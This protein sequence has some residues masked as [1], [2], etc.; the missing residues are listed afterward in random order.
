MDGLFNPLDLIPRIP[1]GDWIDGFISWLL[2]YLRDFTRAFSG[3]LRTAIDYFTDGLVFIPPLLLI[4]FFALVAW[5]MT[6][7]SVAIFSFLGLVL[8][9][10]MGLWGAAM[11]TLAMVLLAATI[12]VLLGIP[13]GI[14]A[15][16]SELVH[17]VVWPI[18]DLMQTMPAFVYLIPAVFFFSLGVV[19]AVMATVIFS[20]P[21]VIRLT[22]LGIQQV[23]KEMVE[24]CGAFG[25]TDWQKLV[26][27]QI[28][29]AMPTIMAGVNQCIMLSLSMVVIAAMIGAGGLGGAVWR[30][31]QR[32]DVGG[33][34]ES[35]LA[36]V[37]VA[38][39]LDRVTQ[40]TSKNR[41][42]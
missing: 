32:L 3:L 16:R 40:R 24:A 5:R 26:K 2:F 20:I 36:V 11:Q 7:R 30:S 27:V 22:G 29:L 6:N 35:G 19:P 15:A 17:R 41:S 4:L 37:I 13:V 38:I 1:L 18:L 42:S 23:P 9:Y 39:V 25:S 10:N 21:P 12:S 33:G 14:M 8:V 34:F 28:P 31:I